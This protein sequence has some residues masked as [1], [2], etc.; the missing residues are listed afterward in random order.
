MIWTENGQ[1]ARTVGV[2]NV[3]GKLIIK[4][5]TVEISTTSAR[6]AKEHG[7]WKE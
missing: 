7:G 5:M 2:K 1:I 6:N 4:R 3:M